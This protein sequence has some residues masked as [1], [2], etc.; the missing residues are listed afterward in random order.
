M[1]VEFAILALFL[2][3]VADG[4]LSIFRMSGFRRKSSS[5]RPDGLLSINVSASGVLE[6]GDSQFETSINRISEQVNTTRRRVPEA[7]RVQK[8]R[9]EW[10]ALII[11]TDEALRVD[12]ALNRIDRL[13]GLLRER[14]GPDVAMCNIDRDMEAR[15]AWRAVHAMLP[16]LP[17]YMPLCYNRKTGE[18]KALPCSVSDLTEWALGRPGADDRP[19]PSGTARLYGEER[20]AE[21]QARTPR[22]EGGADRGGA[23]YVH[24]LGFDDFISEPV[25]RVQALFDNAQKWLLKDGWKWAIEKSSI[26]YVHRNETLYAIFN[27][28]LA[29]GRRV[30]GETSAGVTTNTRVPMKRK[31]FRWASGLPKSLLSQARHVAVQMLADAVDK[32]VL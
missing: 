30:P 8:M 13:V 11:F 12:P 17:R 6:L 22:S 2:L 29:T 23:A 19:N 21:Q 27:S 1:A 18:V 9:L 3:Y 7:A 5:P 25:F 16:D 14:W 20:S 4:G 15:R 26:L 10:P 32:L 31:S 28:G 24:M